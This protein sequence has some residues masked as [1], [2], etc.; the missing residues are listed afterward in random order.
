MVHRYSYLKKW[1]IV[2]KRWAT[3]SIGYAFIYINQGLKYAAHDLQV[4]YVAL[5]VF[6]EFSNN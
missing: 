2:C 6:W 4:F 1:H 3:P 5:N